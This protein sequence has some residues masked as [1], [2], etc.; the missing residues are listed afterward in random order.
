MVRIENGERGEDRRKEGRKDGGN[1]ISREEKRRNGEYKRAK[2]KNERV[3]RREERLKEGSK[4]NE[5]E[6]R[7]RKGGKRTGTTETGKE[8]RK[9]VEM[10]DR[11]GPW[12]DRE[13]DKMAGKRGKKKEGR[14]R[15]MIGEK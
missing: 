14:K 1:N 7:G 12:K 10:S 15:G 4:R 5:E 13:R 9:R 2:E 6:C 8:V 3:K 11:K